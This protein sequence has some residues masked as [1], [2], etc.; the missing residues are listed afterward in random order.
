M[1]SNPSILIIGT[2]DTKSAEMQY[3]EERIKSLDVE[4]KVMDVGVLEGASFPVEYTN[5][6]V[7]RAADTTIQAIIDSGDENT[8]MTLMAQ[9][10]VTL[11]VKLY[12]EGAIDGMIALGGSMGTDLALDVAA[13]LPIGVPKFVVST[14]AF[15]PTI[16]PNRLSPDLMMILWAGGL[17]GLNA[18]CKAVLSQAA[19][20]V[21]GAARAVEKPSKDRPVVG[22]SSLGSSC[23]PY[24][25]TLS[26]E[27]ERR[28]YEVAVFHATGMGGMAIERLAEQKYFCAVL[29][30]ALSELSNE[31]HGGILSAGDGR[32]TAAGKAGIPQI[33]APGA[34]DMVDIATWQEVPERFKDRG[35]HAHNRLIASVGTTPDERINTAKFICNR[36]GQAT[37]PTAFVLPRKGIHNWDVEGGDLYDPE[38]MRVFADAFVDAI[39]SRTDFHNLDIHISDPAFCEQVLNIFD[40]WVEEGIVPRGRS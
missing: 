23:L 33:F 11:A 36:I 6:D 27:L 15:S 2:A 26:P 38:S 31:A 32:L 7:A 24:M 39:P 21:A 1:S 13:A 25:K 8:A 22:M 19:G 9:G 4:A 29:D 16:P 3:L 30:L 28:G 12:S 18:A 20:A 35:Y 10:A 5:E 34:T 40:K 14:I 37:G 17:Y